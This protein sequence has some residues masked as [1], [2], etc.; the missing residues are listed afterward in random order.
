MTHR[1]LIRKEGG[2]SSSS[3]TIVMY[4]SMAGKV[5]YIWPL[6]TPV[7]DLGVQRKRLRAIRE[8]LGWRLMGCEL[9][10]CYES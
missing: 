6:Q 7:S 9:L 8:A 5:Q 1:F 3:S 10:E 2:A 4:R